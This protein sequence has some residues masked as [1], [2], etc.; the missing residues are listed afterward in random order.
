MWRRQAEE[1]EEET[2]SLL[3]SWEL[4]PVAAAATRFGAFGGGI[5]LW[6]SEEVR[7]PSHRLTLCHRTLLSQG[8]DAV[9]QAVGARPGPRVRERRGPQRTRCPPLKPGVV[10]ESRAERHWQ[11]LLHLHSGSLSDAFIQSDLQ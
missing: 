6:L 2:G 8:W 10:N 7:A 1:E 9:S 4:T 11:F 5:S 3:H